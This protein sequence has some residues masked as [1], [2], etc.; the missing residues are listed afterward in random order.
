MAAPAEA[1]KKRKSSTSNPD[2]EESPKPCKIRS[3]KYISLNELQTTGKATVVKIPIKP[4][5]ATKA[6]SKNVAEE[7]RERKKDEIKEINDAAKIPLED[8]NFALSVNK[9]RPSIGMLKPRAKSQAT[10]N[11]EVERSTP[12]PSNSD[13]VDIQRSTPAASTRR[14]LRFA[15]P[16]ECKNEEEG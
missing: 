3:R 9:E 1:E 13:A 8:E 2:K 15:A 12:A 5:R 7:T 16:R 11:I 6:S 4:K 10:Q 14:S